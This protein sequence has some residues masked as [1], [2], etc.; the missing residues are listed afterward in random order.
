FYGA[1][2]FSRDCDVVVL[3]SDENVGRL[4]AALAELLA[5]CIAVPPFERQYLERGHA[6]H[7]RC[8][9][10]EAKGI[11][12]DVMTVLRGCD[13]FESLWE[14]RLTLQDTD[15]T[16]YELLGIEDLVIAKKTQR[17][18]DWPM[19]RRLVEAHY[20]EFQSNP[21]VDQVRFW[22]RESRTPDTLI[23][24]AADHPEILREIIRT[25]PLLAEAMAAS[26]SALLQELRQEEKEER[27]KDEAYWRPLRRELEK[28]RFD[29]G[30]KRC[31]E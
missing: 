10:P 4:N 24:V 21:T 26:C 27:G 16:V 3:A 30:Q 7:F 14:R 11:R 12:L 2:E 1:A 22:L 20:E 8:Q 5:S 31:K 13:G 25:R 19:I 18:K 23:R 15:G 9:H 28:L 29:R 17:D 6:V